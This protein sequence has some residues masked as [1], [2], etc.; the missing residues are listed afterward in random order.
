MWK[1]NN[2]KNIHSHCNTVTGLL[3]KL[4]LGIWQLSWTSTWW[5]LFFFL[6]INFNT[7]RNH[8]SQWR[9]SLELE[10]GHWMLLNFIHDVHTESVV[11]LYGVLWLYFCFSN[12][13]FPNCLHLNAFNLNLNWNSYH[14][15]SLFTNFLETLTDYDYC[16]ISDKWQS[17]TKKTETN[18]K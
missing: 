17:P 7:Q 12:S 10:F 1:K 13:L 18:N 11:T 2:G 5:W 15:H 14:S 3:L 4:E 16:E 6:S 8:Q 9:H